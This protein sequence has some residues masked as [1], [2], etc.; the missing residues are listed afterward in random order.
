MEKK[1]GLLDILLFPK[2]FYEKLTDKLLTLYAGMFFVGLAD[3][4]FALISYNKT[5]VFFGRPIVTLFYNISLTMC[6]IA[7]LGFIDVVFFALPLFDI[8][9][10]FRIKE[11]VK[12]INS[13]LIKLMKVYVVSHFIIVPVN[14]VLLAAG[15]SLGNTVGSELTASVITYALFSEI[16]LPIW[17]S[18]LI[19]RG[20]NT[21]YKFDE[22]LKVLVFVM[23]YT[24]TFLMNYAFMYIIK[25]WLLVLYR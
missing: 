9:K 19:A 17:Y 18:S 15:L 6:I 14:A 13:Q 12:N 5:G 8:F 4:V 3:V 20:I 21:I 22:R 1:N 23:V 25:N 11:R 2:S 16:I 24:W 7:L 10:F